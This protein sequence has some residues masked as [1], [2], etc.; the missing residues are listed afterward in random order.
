MKSIGTLPE[1]HSLLNL[2]IGIP[3]RRP[4][5]PKFTYADVLSSSDFYHIFY[6]GYGVYTCSLDIF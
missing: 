5:F 6:P 1:Q 4:S 2:F 3:L